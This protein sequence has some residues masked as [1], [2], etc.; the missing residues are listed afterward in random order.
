MGSSLNSFS[1]GRLIGEEERLCRL[2]DGASFFGVLTSSVF[3]VSPPRRLMEC[4]SFSSR[5]VPFRL[6][7][8]GFE[9]KD[10]V[11]TDRTDCDLA[12]EHIKTNPHI[13]KLPMDLQVSRADVDFSTS[14]R[15]QGDEVQAFQS[16]EPGV[17]YD[18]I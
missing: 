7:F 3:I 1:L 6:T 15:D 5:T 11:G 14:A 13:D 18:K 10:I 2:V 9:A 17:K 12:I 16:K 4:T 8:F